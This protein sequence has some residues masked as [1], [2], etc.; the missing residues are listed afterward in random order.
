MAAKKTDS[1]FLR[2]RTPH[3][4]GAG[5]E[6]TSYD[7]G[8][9]V[10]ALGKS[11]LRIHNIQVAWQQ[12]GEPGKGPNTGSG[13]DLNCYYQLTTQSQSAPVLM[14]DPSVIS[15]GRLFTGN[16]SSGQVIII[17]EQANMNPMDFTQ[18]YLIAVDELYLGVDTDTAV[19]GA[20][21]CT[22]VLECTVEK[23]DE[24]AAM[25]LALSQSN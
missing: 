3:A 7:L 20:F 19:G 10:D 1:F 11:V 24:R 18:G 15:C 16:D 6:Q 5:F 25:A 21:S 12:D 14:D 22:L 23:M 2:I 13:T 8:A 4:T 17:D 9:Y